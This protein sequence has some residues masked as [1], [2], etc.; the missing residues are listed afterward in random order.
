MNDLYRK[1]AAAP[2]HYAL[3]GVHAGA[4]EAELKSAHRTLAAMLHPDR[5]PSPTAA[6]LMA[7]VNVAYTCLGDARAAASY[8]RSLQLL[9]GVAT[10]PDCKGKGYAERGKGFSG[11]VVRKGCVE[12]RGSGVVQRAATDPRE[13]KRAQRSKS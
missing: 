6:D 8:A 2:H 1:L 10:C 13:V 4:T 12:C 7:R 9:K 11:A 3:L 5:N